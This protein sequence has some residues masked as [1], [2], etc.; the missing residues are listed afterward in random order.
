MKE[1]NEMHAVMQNG[2]LTLTRNFSRMLALARARD[3]RDWFM[4]GTKP[5][6][7]P[8]ASG[9]TVKWR[10]IDTVAGE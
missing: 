10:R 7:L 5:G 4:F 9:M 3:T 1:I 6:W 8:K 2:L